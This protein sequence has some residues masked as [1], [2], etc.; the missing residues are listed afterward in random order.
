MNKIL[1]VDDDPDVRINVKRYLSDN[2]FAVVCS[3]NA[4]EAFLVMERER[5]ELVLLDIMLPGI[6]GYEFCNKIKLQGDIPII[7]VSSLAAEEDRVQGLLCGGDDYMTKPISLKE[8]CLRIRAR[9]RD[10][11]SDSSTGYKMGSISIEGGRLVKGEE[12]L[13]L[14]GKELE[15]LLLLWRNSGKT[16]AQDEIYRQIWRQ[17]DNNDIRAVRFHMHN[18]RQ[19]L[20]S[21]YPEKEYIKTKW[22]GGYTFTDH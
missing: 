2:G 17:D 20:K 21:F 13:T 11:K 22:G 16:L 3:E 18:L 12:K 19:K 7:F 6:N 1:I 14:T 15:I 5:P 10:K 4:E 8:L 9:L